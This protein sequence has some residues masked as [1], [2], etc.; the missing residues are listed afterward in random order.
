MKNLN[1]F[2]TDFFE[3]TSSSPSENHSA[4]FSAIPAE[5][6]ESVTYPRPW[7]NWPDPASREGNVFVL[8]SLA[9]GKLKE[10]GFSMEAESLRWSVMRGNVKSYGELPRILWK[11]LD[12]SPK[13][14][15]EDEMNR[16]RSVAE[17]AGINLGESNL[18][19]E[20]KEPEIKNILLPKGG[21]PEERL[22][23]VLSKDSSET[24]TF[25]KDAAFLLP[26][27][28]KAFWSKKWLSGEMLDKEASFVARYPLAWGRLDAFEETGTAQAFADLGFEDCLALCAWS[29]RHMS[30]FMPEEDAR[31]ILWDHSSSVDI[32][33]AAHLAQKAF[34]WLFGFIKNPSE[35]RPPLWLLEAADFDSPAS[36]EVL[37]WRLFKKDNP[38]IYSQVEAMVEKKSL[39][40][41]QLVIYEQWLFAVSAMDVPRERRRAK[42]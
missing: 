22:A 12:F 35:N 3:S 38:L 39:S 27:S 41:E 24:T 29:R 16:L 28:D 40:Q 7:F 21:G 19:I 2:F 17:A 37:L 42:I 15:P 20:R 23:F 34:E 10:A 9:C 18:K 36:K 30:R 8:L 26:A 33:A 14:L 1:A 5:E 11:F 6:L 4:G 31:R 25:G 32:Y 13:S